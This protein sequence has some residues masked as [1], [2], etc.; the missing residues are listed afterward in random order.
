[1]AEDHVRRAHVYKNREV[2]YQTIISK[3]SPFQARNISG[4]ISNF[5]STIMSQFITTHDAAGKATFSSKGNLTTN[6]MPLGKSTLL[7]STHTATP[8]TITEADL[9]QYLKDQISGFGPGVPCPDGGSSISVVQVAPGLA[10]PMRSLNTLGVFYMLEGEVKLVL[11]GGEERVLKK[12][13]SGVLRGAAH[14][15]KNEGKEWA[16]LIAFSQGLV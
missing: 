4:F 6:T 5:Q 1:M 8:N 12:G 11:D 9:D 7:Y 14:S 10:S 16:K 15:W 2:H 13:D 3:T